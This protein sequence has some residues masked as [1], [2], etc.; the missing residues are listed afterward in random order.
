MIYLC[1]V[2]RRKAIWLRRISAI[3]LLLV[4]L[5]V[6][7]V[8]VTHSHATRRQTNSSLISFLLKKGLP[9]HQQQTSDSKCF[10][11]EY[12]LAKDVDADFSFFVVPVSLPLQSF[13][14]TVYNFTFQHNYSFSETRGP[15]AVV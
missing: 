15:P 14:T 4:L 11:C 12:Q 5:A 13:T 7:F 3:F 10:I 8:Q 6:Q 2:T 9:V 1:T